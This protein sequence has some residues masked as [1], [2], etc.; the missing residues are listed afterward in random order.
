MS[1][2]S[3][4]NGELR[5]RLVKGSAW[6]FWQ[7]HKPQT[8]CYY[9]Y[10][11]LAAGQQADRALH[12][13]AFAETGS[14]A[15]QLARFLEEPRTTVALEMDPDLLRSWLADP[16]AQTAP[17]LVGQFGSH[18]SGYGIKPVDEQQVEVIYAADRRHEWLGVFTEVDAFA[19][20]ELDY[21]RRRRRCLIC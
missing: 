21:D 9:L 3:A 14:L 8:G 15:A 20:I 16:S 13:G 17:R 4:K 11:L 2:L 1:D 12:L 19:F 18:W 10:A 7:Y 5:E 6:R